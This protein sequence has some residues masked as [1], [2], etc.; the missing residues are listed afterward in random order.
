MGTSAG[1]AQMSAVCAC[2]T[3]L[4]RSRPPSRLPRALRQRQEAL[5]LHLRVLQAFIHFHSPSHASVTVNNLSQT[6]PT[7]NLSQQQWSLRRPTVWTIMIPNP[8]SPQTS[9]TSLLPLRMSETIHARMSPTSFSPSGDASSPLLAR[10]LRENLLAR[11]LRGN[12]MVQS[13]HH[14]GSLIVHPPRKMPRSAVIRKPR[15]KL[16]FDRG[17]ER[18]YGAFSMIPWPFPLAMRSG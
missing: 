4:G 1:W 16:P 7:A 3:W 12:S 14:F 2:A 10:P 13:H 18:H 9:I 8:C 15:F 6:G 11:P 17:T 5:S